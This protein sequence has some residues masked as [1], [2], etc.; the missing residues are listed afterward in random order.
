MR[1]KDRG[2]Y[3]VEQGTQKPS[4]VFCIFRIPGRIRDLIKWVVT[5]CVLSSS[6]HL[7]AVYPGIFPSTP[8][9]WEQGHH[10]SRDFWKD[11]QSWGQ[12]IYTFEIS[13]V[14]FPPTHFSLKDLLTYLHFSMTFQ[15][16]KSV[17]YLSFLCDEINQRDEW[18]LRVFSSEVTAGKARNEV[19]CWVCSWG[20]DCISQA[21]MILMDSMPFPLPSY[22]SIF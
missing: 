14:Y 6:Y 19:L 2:L 4:V 10:V 18:Q 3:Y 16:K 22:Q 11:Y 21:H 1:F 5:D 12:R 9:S 13:G 8:F 15:K 7:H 17:K 20:Q